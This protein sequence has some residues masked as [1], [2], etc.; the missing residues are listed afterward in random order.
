MAT[1]GKAGAARA[2]AQ[3]APAAAATAPSPV[4]V[5][6]RAQTRPPDVQPASNPVA[7]A[8][9]R[10]L[11]CYYTVSLAFILL[12][13]AMA[14]ERSYRFSLPTHDDLLVDL[15]AKTLTAS[16]LIERSR[17]QAESQGRFYF[18]TSTFYLLVPYLPETDAGRATLIVGF[19]F[20]TISAVAGL[21]A[22]MLGVPAG[23]LFVVVHYGWL[24]YWRDF[25]PTSTFTLLIHGALL[26]FAV[27]MG[28][29]LYALR[30][31]DGWFRRAL[32]IAS[33]VLFAHSLMF[34]EVMAVVFTA[35]ACFLAL[36]ATLGFWWPWQGSTS[37]RRAFA[38]AAPFIAVFAAYL[39]VYVGYRAAH[40]PVYDGNRI[41]AES[42]A[43]IR[44]IWTVVSQL[45]LTGLPAANLY[46]EHEFAAQHSAVDAKAG[47]WEIM[48]ANA[49]AGML[50]F[51]VLL[52]FATVVY[53]GGAPGRRLRWREAAVWIGSLLLL[54]FALPLPIALTS[55][56]QQVIGSMHTYLTAYLSFLCFCIMIVVLATAIATAKWPHAARM[57][58]CI[59]FAST[60]GLLGLGTN[61]GNEGT[62]ATLDA[63][64]AKWRLMKN[65]LRTPYVATIPANATIV[66]PALFQGVAFDWYWTKF[67]EVYANRKL[68][69]VSA[70]P[71]QFATQPGPLYY[72]DIHG[73]GVA[74]PAILTITG[75]M[76]PDRKPMLAES[77]FLVT[78][79]GLRHATV[80]FVS[81][82]ASRPGTEVVE[83]H[84]V[85]AIAS[86]SGV[87]ATALGVATGMRLG[88]LTAAPGSATF[89]P[90]VQLPGSNP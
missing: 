86:V 70:L 64:Y 47:V 88:T 49:T 19:Q 31:P 46:V 24:A 10:A 13:L 35:L 21:L 3:A 67:A 84:W 6:A 41:T 1:R 36:R 48:G 29:W 30:Q 56:Y 73:G 37:A 45:A 17:V 82:D 87:P 43:N 8:P 18:Y 38:S 80:S 85:P 51:A 72:L 7:A 60:V 20:V 57:S 71:A 16:E 53:A 12:A 44:G 90:P 33:L 25:Y 9:S 5:S 28:A 59:L 22:H 61:V 74:A 69:I 54:A 11:I 76:H 15:N 32:K 58:V 23:I 83:S 75:T 42:A 26:W 40:P 4:D 62:L 63:H 52:A 2:H 79:K 81:E 14:W 55:K 65:F 66:S 34:Y 50:A 78:D 68:N 77:A 27:S 39:L 89:R